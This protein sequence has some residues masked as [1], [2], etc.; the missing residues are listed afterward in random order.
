MRQAVNAV[1]IVLWFSA[2]ALGLPAQVSPAKAVEWIQVG[3]DGRHFVLAHSKADFRVWGFNYDHDSGNR[4]LEDYWQTEWGRV[5]ADFR[6]MKALG[7]NTIRIHLQVSKF[8]KSPRTPDAKSLQRLALLVELAEKTGVYLDLTGLGCYRKEDVPQ[9]Y[10]ELTES[11]RWATQ[12]RFWEAVAQT[13]KESPAVFCYDL[14]NEPVVSED[15]SHRDWTPGAFGDRY[16]VQRLT[17]EFRGRSTKQIAE[18]WVRKMAMAI[19]RYDRKHLLTVG[20]IPWA[21]TWTNAQPLFYSKEVS[22]ELDFVSLHFYPQHSQIDKAL[23]ALAV[24]DIGKPILI[25]EMFPLNCS[26]AELNEFIDGSKTITSGWLGFYWGKTIN[27]YKAESRTVADE[28]A[29]GWLE[30]FTSKTPAIINGSSG[31]K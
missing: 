9:W 5:T 22:R 24:Y 27:E 23:M 11:E 6:E 31:R 20:A 26:V 3:E 8:M 13:C 18:A 19:H 21:L 17:L 28:M 2:L 30:Y 1:H 12:A 14:M 25:E 16:F 10:N 15:K 29:L 7:A 4:L